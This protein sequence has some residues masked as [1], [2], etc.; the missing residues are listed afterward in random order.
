MHGAGGDVE[1]VPGRELVALQL[2]VRAVTG[3]YLDFAKK[4]LRDP[5]LAKS[6]S[7]L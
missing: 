6:I 4:L 5:A 3:K 7:R 1:D 2:A